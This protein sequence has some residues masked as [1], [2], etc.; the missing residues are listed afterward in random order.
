MVTPGFDKSSWWGV[1]PDLVLVLA[2]CADR[3]RD[4]VAG[5]VWG[6]VVVEPSGQDLLAVAVESPPHHRAFRQ[7]PY[8]ASTSSTS[9]A[10]SGEAGPA[11]VA[12][13][14]FWSSASLRVR[15]VTRAASARLVRYPSRPVRS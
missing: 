4:E 2:E 8:R 10:S 14:A 6:L 3:F 11:G 1:E 12:S 5:L 13:S 7:R 9:I 15:K